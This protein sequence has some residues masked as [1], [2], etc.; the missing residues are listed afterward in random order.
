MAVELLVLRVV[1]VV[2]GI[3]WVGA[4]A[5][6]AFFL[7]PAMASAGPAAGQVAAG[8]MRRKIFV[9]MPVVAIL[10][11]LAGIRLLMITSGGFAGDYFGRRAGMTF[12]IAGAI[13][14]IAFIYGMAV[15]R[16]AMAKVVALTQ[17]AQS[18]PANRERIMAEIQATQQRAARATTVVAWLLLVT[19]VGMAIGR[20]M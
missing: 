11:I 4:M 1:H 6:N 9:F 7:G 13:A 2:G 16:P 20:Y 10:T 8:L 3:L 12:A 17:Q 18:D 14:L 5:F 19:A 15:T